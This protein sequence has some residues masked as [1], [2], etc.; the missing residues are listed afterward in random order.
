M[1]AATAR[2][3]K[4]RVLQAALTQPGLRAIRQER[5]FQGRSASQRT[6]LS[7]PLLPQ[8]FVLNRKHAELVLSDRSVERL[9]QL[10]CYTSLER[11]NG[12]MWERVCYS[13]GRP[14]RELGAAGNRF[15]NSCTNT[16][17]C[18]CWPMTGQARSLLTMPLA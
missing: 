1:G 7:L 18:R 13:G 10:N 9:F 4:Q 15:V 8:W 11:A 3:L 2:Q 17:A 14:L 12:K 6:C 5:C 16:R